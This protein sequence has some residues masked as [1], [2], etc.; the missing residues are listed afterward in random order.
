MTIGWRATADN[1]WDSAPSGASR[2]ASACRGSW[3][4]SSRSRGSSILNSRTEV[5]Y[6]VHA[7]RALLQRHPERVLRVSL[8]HGRSDAR[9]TQIEQLAQAAGRPI[10]RVD[11]GRLNARL[12]D[13]THQ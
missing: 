5:I 3:Q 6:G 4:R 10:E 9:A 13:V 8:Q 12:G 1:G 7:V 2:R 11:A